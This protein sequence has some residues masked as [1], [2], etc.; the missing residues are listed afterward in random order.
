MKT[1]DKIRSNKLA[2]DTRGLTTVEYVIL[3]CLI[4]VFAVGTWQTFGK[5]VGKKIGDSTTTLTKTIGE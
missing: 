4:A 3:L 2:R 1:I 5:Y